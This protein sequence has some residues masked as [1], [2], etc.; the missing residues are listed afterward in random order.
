MKRNNF[1]KWALVVFLVAWS[2]WEIY[3]PTSRDLIE[4]FKRDATQT[5][6]KFN[7][8]VKRAEEIRNKDQTRSFNSLKTAIGTN[9]IKPY[10]SFIDTKAELD[11]TQTILNRLQRNALGKIK[12]GLD[13]Q[14]GTSFL[15]G[16]DTSKLDQSATNG[17]AQSEVKNRALSQAVE[18]LRRR[19]D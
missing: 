2:I 15:V 18:V 12:L 11:P 9:D 19:I 17:I 3:P 1:W 14:G 8:I 13:L 10:F 7:D 5:D 4:Q 16:M 6:A